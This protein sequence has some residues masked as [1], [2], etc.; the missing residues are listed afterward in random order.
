[1]LQRLQAGGDRQRQRVRGADGRGARLLA[2]PDHPRAVRGRRAVPAQHV[3]PMGRLAGLRVLEF[4][5]IGPGPFAG[6][7]LADMGADVLLVD[8]PTR[9]G[10]GLGRERRLRRHAARPPLGHARPEVAREAPRRRCASRAGRRA[11]RGLPARRDGA[12]RPRPRR[13]LARNPRLVYGRMTGWGQDGPLADARR[14][15]HQLHRARRACCTRSAAPAQRPV[16]P[17]NLVGDFGGGG[18]LLAFGIAC[19]AASRRALA[20]AARSSTPRWST[21]R[22]CSATMFAG[23]LAAGLAATS[24]AS[25]SS[26]RGAPWYDTYETRD[27][28]LRRGRRD[29]AEVLRRAART[30]RPRPAMRCRR[31]T[32]AARWPALRDAFAARFATQRATSGAPRSKAPTPASR[33]CCR[34]PKRARIRTRRARGARRGRRYRPAR[35]GAAL[36][37][38][39][40][41]GAAAAA[42]A[43]QR[44]RRGA[45]GLGLRGDE[46]A[47]LRALG[48]R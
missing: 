35:A 40:G 13:L 7:M 24:A 31:S 30:A 11:D 38:H 2:R 8:R 1:M 18:M 26:T 3:A 12:P 33:R 4:E 9:P 20:A 17:L 27:G 14:P 45:A 6:M 22:R 32:T 43:R 29:R 42:R 47:A 21:A 16:P 48:A 34:S 19:G 41:R 37:A 15:R 44:R 28:Q 39:A 10:L 25:T 5:A 46:I 23:M 36:R